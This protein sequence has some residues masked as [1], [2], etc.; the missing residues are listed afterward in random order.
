[1]AECLYAGSV[2]NCCAVFKP[3]SRSVQCI[4]QFPPLTVVDSISPCAA[5]TMEKHEADRLA[6]NENLEKN[7]TEYSTRDFDLGQIVNVESTPDEERTVRR[8]LD[9]L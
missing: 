7:D 9:Y 3:A 8:K 4:Q 1:M 2:V 5:V 6:G